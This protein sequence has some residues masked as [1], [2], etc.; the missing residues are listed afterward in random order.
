MRWEE[1]RTHFHSDS[2]I[3]QNV[4][5]PIQK[6]FHQNIMKNIISECNGMK[7]IQALPFIFFSLVI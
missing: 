3:Y 5:F 4:H 2:F 6:A 7:H 1:E